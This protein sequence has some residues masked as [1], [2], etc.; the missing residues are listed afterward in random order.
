V[1]KHVTII[2]IS[3]APGGVDF[4]YAK[5]LKLNAK[6]YLGIPGKIAPRASADILVSEVNTLL[7]ERSD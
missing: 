6:L 3:S 2:D 7:K 5:H 4:E 1:D